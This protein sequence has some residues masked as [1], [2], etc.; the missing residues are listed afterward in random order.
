MLRR[1]ILKLATGAAVLGA[2]RVARAQRERTLKFVPLINLALL[3]PVFSGNRATHNH[4]YLVFDT[5]YGLDETLTA[6]P[7]MVE[8]H[9]VEEGGTLWTLRLREGLRFHDDTPVLARDAVASIRRFAARDPFGQALLAATGELSAPDDRTVRFRLTRPFPHLP[10][11][12]AGSSVTTPAVMPERL[13]SSDPFRPVPEIVGSGPYRF[14]AGGFN[15]GERAA[16]ERFAAYAPRSEGL[17]SYTAA[18]PRTRT[19]SARSSS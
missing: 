11:A 10:A 16:Y 15:A 12:L 8:G 14:L 9:A 4:A 3:D 19:A 5:L 1:D 13:A 6:R 17:S 2:P 18:S 7:Q